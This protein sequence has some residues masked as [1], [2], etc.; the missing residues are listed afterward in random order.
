MQ[1]DL[2]SNLG[3]IFLCHTSILSSVKLRER[4]ELFNFIALG[5]RTSGSPKQC[6][7]SV[8]FHTYL[9]DSLNLACLQCVPSN[10]LRASIDRIEHGSEDWTEV[11]RRAMDGLHSEATDTC[12]QGVDGVCSMLGVCFSRYIRLGAG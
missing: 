11:E 5:N 6:N 8:F 12:G 2:D 1:R 4:V 7:T 10:Q 3:I 9:L